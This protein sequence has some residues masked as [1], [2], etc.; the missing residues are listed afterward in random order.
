MESDLASDRTVF[1]IHVQKQG[2]IKI[3]YEI[4]VHI[5]IYNMNGN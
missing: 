5:S 2:Y 4:A 1:L 3:A